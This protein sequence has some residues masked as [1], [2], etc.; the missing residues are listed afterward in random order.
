MTRASFM[1][2]ALVLLLGP[3]AL[4]KPAAAPALTLE[5]RV[6]ATTRPAPHCGTGAFA[7]KV[8]FQVEEVVEGDYKQPSVDVIV[9]CPEMCPIRLVVGA[10]AQLVLAREAP[11]PKVS[12]A[13]MGELP[14]PRF[15]EF[16]LVRAT[17]RDGGPS[18][19]R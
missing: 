15:P 5:G 7:I 13:F 11:R 14:A 19:P 16:W 3:H 4:A 18:K 9:G 12:W 6:T 8:R 1:T 10:R 2:V 17:Q